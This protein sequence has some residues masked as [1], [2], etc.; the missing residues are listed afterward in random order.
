[1]STYLSIQVYC[2]K[3]HSTAELFIQTLH[4]SNCAGSNITKNV[5]YGTEEKQGPKMPNRNT[6][7]VS[8][9]LQFKQGLVFFDM[10]QVSHYRLRILLF[11]I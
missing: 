8:S 5:D 9:K 7:I 3:P 11:M 2:A 10:F 1:M 6:Q 4:L